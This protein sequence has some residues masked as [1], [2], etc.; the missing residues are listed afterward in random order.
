L[1]GDRKLTA[2]RVNARASTGPKSAHGRARSARNA[3]RHGLSLPVCSNRATSE[4]VEV[5]AREIAGTEANPEILDLARRVAEAQIDL[6]RVRSARHHFLADT[7]RHPYRTN[8]RKK[9]A[10]LR[11]LQQS[12]APDIPLGDVM[13]V[14]NS[15]VEGP[16]KFTAILSQEAEK[17]LSMDRY[18]RRALSRRKTAIRVFDDARRRP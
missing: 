16:Q 2:N 17:L 18:E 15:T 13:K 10:L 6:Q 7:L 3:F 8:L 1:I 5:L 9:A 12:N 4:Q 14:L 11:A